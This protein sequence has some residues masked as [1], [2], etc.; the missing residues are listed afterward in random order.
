MAATTTREQTA[1]DAPRIT[2]EF[3]R[4]RRPR[5][6]ANCGN[7]GRFVRREDEGSVGRWDEGWEPDPQCGAGYGCGK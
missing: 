5:T 7:C 1:T 2:V 3:D 6:A 4:P